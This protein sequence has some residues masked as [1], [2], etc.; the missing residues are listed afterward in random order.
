MFLKRL[1]WAQP[2]AAKAA[3]QIEKEILKNVNIS[4]RN[5]SFITKTA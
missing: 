4:V 1:V 2:S 5:S 3:G